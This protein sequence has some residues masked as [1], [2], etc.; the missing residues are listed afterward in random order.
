MEKYDLE[1]ITTNRF[2]KHHPEAWSFPK[3]LGNKILSLIF[4]A[5]FGL[6]VKDCQSGMWVIRRGLLKKMRLMSN[7]MEFSVEIKALALKMADDK[8]LEVP[9][10]YGKRLSHSVKLRL[11]RDFLRNFLCILFMK[12]KLSLASAL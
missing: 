5:L 11:I 12:V 9:I 2:Y 6:K 7:G 8:F 1:F 10:Y 4:I 3:I